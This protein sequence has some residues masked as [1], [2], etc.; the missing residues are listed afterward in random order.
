LGGHSQ[1]YRPRW[2]HKGVNSIAFS[3]DGGILA[4][5]GDDNQLKLWNPRTGKLLGTLEGHLAS[6]RCVAFSPDGRI[7]ASG[8]DDNQLKLWNP[9]TGK[10]LG[11]FGDSGSRVAFSSDG[12]IL[13]SSMPLKIWK[14][15]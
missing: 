7:L 6:V 12:R 4:S 13:A 11:I 8:G 10:L 9:S 2:C 14:I 15:R 3:P 1:G 5:G